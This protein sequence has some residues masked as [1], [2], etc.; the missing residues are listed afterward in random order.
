[1]PEGLVYQRYDAK[2]EL[3]VSFRVFTLEKD[4]DNFTIWMNDPRVAEFWE[5]A[6]SR[7]KLAEFAQQRLADPHIIPL[8][9]EFNGHPF[10]Y[11]EAYWVCLLYTSPSPRDL[12]LSRMPSSA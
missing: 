2:S 9:A 8:I 10:G 11:I 6:W 4:L 3:T 7:E 1:M 5:Q 12:D